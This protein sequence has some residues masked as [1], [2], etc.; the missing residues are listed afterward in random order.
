MKRTT[1]S[2]MIVLWFTLFPIVAHAQESSAR[3]PLTN[4]DIVKMVRAGLDSALIVTTIQGGK[5]QF[6]VTPDALIDLK[7]KGVPDAVVKAMVSPTTAVEG[8]KVTPPSGDD[9][10]DRLILVDGTNRLPLEIAKIEVDSNASI[11]TVF[12][13][14]FGGKTKGYATFPAG[15]A[16]PNR[17]SNKSPI[18]VDFSMQSG[19]RIEDRVVLAKLE[20]DKVKNIRRLVVVE[21]SMYE[22]GNGGMPAA[23]RVPLTFTE[24]PAKVIAGKKA[25]IF[26]ATPV[27]PLEPGEYAF[28]IG[29]SIFIDFGI[30][31]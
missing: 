28:V 12:G 3:R 22:N 2:L 23:A 15:P 6:N 8:A 4:T 19:Y 26:T 7:K 30:D 5:N 17:S 13:G 9:D 18:F 14:L 10:D 31:P 21:M 20:I 1:Q 11:G 25:R 27:S 24:K 29:D 16:S